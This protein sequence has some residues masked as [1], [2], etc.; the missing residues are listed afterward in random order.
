M[1]FI[2]VASALFAVALAAP[3]AQTTDCPNP[4]HCGEP[5]DPASYENID[6]TDYYV[7]KNEGIQNVSFKLSG[8]NATGISCEIGAV[9]TIP[10]E[11]VTCGESDY[12]FGVVEDPN[13]GSEAGIAVYHQ[14]SPFAGKWGQGSVPTYCRAGG[15]GPNDFVCN[16]VSEVTIVIQ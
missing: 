5:A 11:V 9:P 8:N 6:I 13:G 16:Q 1:Q 15:N 4:A 12:R 2:T 7:R 3:T 10:S 14:T